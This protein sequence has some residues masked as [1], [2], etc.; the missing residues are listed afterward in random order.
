MFKKNTKKL[1]KILRKCGQKTTKGHGKK[2]KKSQKDNDHW[3]TLVVMHILLKY[4]QF[5][6]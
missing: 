6:I 1:K 5:L 3:S 2:K 4:F